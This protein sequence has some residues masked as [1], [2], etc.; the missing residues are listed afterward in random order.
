MRLFQDRSVVAV[1]LCMIL[2]AVG[3]FALTNQ[4]LSSRVLGSFAA[5]RPSVPVEWVAMRTGSEMSRDNVD[6]HNLEFV[7]DQKKDV[8]MLHVLG[9]FMTGGMMVGAALAEEVSGEIEIEE[10]PPPYF[11]VVFAI[12]ILGGVGLLTGSL[13]DVMTEEAQLGMMSGARAK[14]EKERSR[15]SYF[16]K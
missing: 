1:A 4:R 13:G 15:S 3:G 10:L 12:A 5:S 9:G 14:K 11:A 2:Q 16:K 8:S 7:I 6:G